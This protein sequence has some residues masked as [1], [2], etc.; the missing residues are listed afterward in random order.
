MP[1]LQLLLR[2]WETL[3]NNISITFFIFLFCFIAY[4][5][6]SSIY[7]GFVKISILYEFCVLNPNRSL[8]HNVQKFLLLRCFLTS[9]IFL[10]ASSSISYS[11]P[12]R[13][14]V[15]PITRNNRTRTNT[16]RTWMP[17]DCAYGNITDMSIVPLVQLGQLGHSSW[18][19]G[20]SN[21][22]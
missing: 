15:F 11:M 18:R 9:F 4:I 22:L 10:S 3:V 17:T 21:F 14:T 7:A 5:S 16:R 12:T 8:D 13:T 20:H 2:V 1:T 19:A 6:S